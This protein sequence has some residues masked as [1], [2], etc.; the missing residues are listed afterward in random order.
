MMDN[1]SGKTELQNFCAEL[2]VGEKGVLFEQ[3]T[4]KEEAAEA[5]AL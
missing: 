5:D 1:C 4:E 2:L 3:P